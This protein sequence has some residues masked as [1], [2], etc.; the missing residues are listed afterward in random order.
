MQLLYS[1]TSPYV[2]KV[3]VVAFEKGIED[4][5]ER[6]LT[7][8]LEPH[9][10]FLARNP[11]GKIPVLISDDGEALYDS[12]V[13]AEYL[14]ASFPGPRLLPPA[15]PARFHALRQQALADGLLDAGV[16]RLLEGRR[17]EAERSQAWTVKQTGV[18]ARALDAL[19]A[20]AAGLHDAITIG[21]IAIGCAL[22][23][24]DFRFPHEPWRNARPALAEWFARFSQ[25]RSM[26]ATIPHETPM[27]WAHQPEGNT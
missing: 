13:I 11:L 22:G 12:P 16:A 1:P 5:I 9:A 17:P 21:A 27:P 18:V 2:R 20:E 6:R 3:L 26:Q 24:L 14:D 10:D 7:N 15:G 23:W 25:R 4:R 8:I 19:E